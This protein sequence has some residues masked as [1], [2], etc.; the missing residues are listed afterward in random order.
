VRVRAAAVRRADPPA[1]ESGGGFDAVWIIVAVLLAVAAVPGWMLFA[2]RAP[3]EPAGEPQPGSA[4]RP[5]GAGPAAL[6]APE[7][8]RTGRL[9]PPSQGHE[10]TAEITWR[11]S[12]AECRFSVTAVPAR[13]GAHRTLAE[14]AALEWPPAG[15][16]GVQAMTDAVEAL[17]RSLLA[18]G[19]RPLPPGDAWYA[20]RFASPPMTQSPARS[21]ERAGSPS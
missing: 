9:G 5:E 3:E 17:E 10:S 21:R 8:P 2:R 15:P 4:P 18:D 19:W 6:R 13:G 16:S 1:R 11:R 7:R 12:G 20:K 14:T